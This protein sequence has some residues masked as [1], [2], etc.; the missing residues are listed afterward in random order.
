LLTVVVATYLAVATPIAVVLVPI[1][2]LVEAIV[3]RP[4]S[5]PH[6]VRVAV[7]STAVFVALAGAALARP[8]FGELG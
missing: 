8:V 1:V 7:V 4:S 3:D 6:P 5:P 2:S